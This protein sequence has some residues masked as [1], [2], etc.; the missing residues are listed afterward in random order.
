MLNLNSVPPGLLFKCSPEKFAEL[1]EQE[2]IVPAPYVGRYK[3]VLVEDLEVL[4][5]PELTELV[6][7]SYEMVAAKAKIGK[8]AT[9]KKIREHQEEKKVVPAFLCVLDGFSPRPLRLKALTAKDA[10]KIMPARK[11]FSTLFDSRSPAGLASHSPL[12]HAISLQVIHSAAPD[13]FWGRGPGFRYGCNSGSGASCHG[14]ECA[15]AGVARRG[16]D[17]ES[18]RQR[19]GRGGGRRIHLGGGV[20]TG[21]KSGRRRLHADPHGGRQNRFIDYREKAP[22]AATANMYLD[23]KGNVIEEASTVGYKAI[24]VPGSVAGMVYAEQKYGK[25]SLER[26]MAP[27]IKLARDGFVLC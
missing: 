4:S 9:K 2:G 17:D 16:A 6:R 26:V 13:F 3:W 20:S 10:E 25:L 24:G 5:W 12:L 18:R 1:V 14:G 22:A 21:G 7:T 15:P 23:A 27:A 19:G 11:E 8:A